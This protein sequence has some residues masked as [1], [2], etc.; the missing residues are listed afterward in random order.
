MK[1]TGLVSPFLAW[2]RAARKADTVPYPREKRPGSP[3]YR[4]FHI[5]DIDGCIGCGRCA[6]ICQ[7]AAIDMVRV[8]GREPTRGDSGLRP[9]IDYGR[10]CWCALCVDVCSTGSLGM[11]N[12]YSWNSYRPDTF[13][14]TPGAEARAWDR[15]ELGYR[16][17]N[18]VLGWAG[19]PREH[20]PHRDP[21]D[22]IADFHEVVGGYDDKAARREASRCIQCGLCVTACPAHMYIPEYI[23]AIA[24]GRCDEAVRIFYRNNPLPE[25]CGK[26]C[27]RECEKVCAMGHQGEAIAIRWLKRFACERFESLVPVLDAGRA[28][29]TGRSVAVIG[30]GPAGLTAAYYL[31]LA[32]FEV[33]V[34]ERDPRGGG[35]AWSAIPRYRLPGD[36][37]R[38]QMEVIESAG[39][40]FHFGSAVDADAFD[41]LSREHDAVFVS[42]G[43]QR[44]LPLG[45]PGDDLP[46]VE[47]AFDFLRTVG[48]GNECRPVGG[49]VLVVG[50]G[51]V[52]IDAARTARRLGAAVT[53]SY[54]RRIEDMPADAD[55]IREAVEEG[56]DIRDRTIPL[57]IEQEGRGLGFVYAAAEMVPDPAGGRPRPVRKDD[58]EHRIVVDTV[59][60]AI[61]QASDLSFLPAGAASSIRVERGM[62]IV[63]EDQYTGFG[64]VFA[65]GDL[66]PGPGDAIS[67][68]ADGLR[69]VKGIRRRLTRS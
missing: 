29:A 9:R 48:I 30:A 53:I 28:P 2:S 42:T 11:S 13:V 47:Q 49:R 44:S 7:N 38:K 61:G 18:S 57:R 69:A 16:Q 4:G 10:C 52:A 51:N 19:S 50:G 65:G 67:A 15:D 14:F 43:L 39:A 40:R 60:A 8:P 26:V 62:V 25:M 1:F 17:D 64:N 58:G 68:I 35:V 33:H 32:G 66:T 24:D 31:S 55:E 63:D 46:G 27:T 59:M 5:N 22:R 12:R 37:F 6:E 54:R 3:R 21:A 45:I 56:V 36:G 23:Q 41:R 20:M 34:H